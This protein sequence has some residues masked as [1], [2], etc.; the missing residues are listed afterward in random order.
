[1]FES[2]DSDTE[3]HQV[4]ISYTRADHDFASYLFDWLRGAGFEPWM[5]TKFL[6]PGQNWDFEINHALQNSSFIIV[7]LSKRSVDKRGYI[8]RE[9]KIALDLY[10]DKLIDDI[11]IIPVIIDDDILI[12]EQIKHLQYVS[13]KQPGYETKIAEAINIQ[14]ERL[15]GQRK[16]TQEEKDVYWSF[17]TKKEVWDG[18][19]GYEFEAQYISLSSDRFVNICEISDFIRGIILDH[20]FD[21][22]KNKIEQDAD[23]HSFADDQWSRTNTF[24]ASCSEPI[25]QNKFI[26][27]R[28][29]NS[30]YGAGAA[31]P[32]NYFETFCFI[33]DPLIRIRKLMDIFKNQDEALKLIRQ[34]VFD[35]L[36]SEKLEDGSNMLEEDWI[37]QGTE[38]W[39]SFSSFIFLAENI[40]ILFPP[41]SVGPYAA[42]S[43]EVQIPYKD[44][45]PLI[46]NQYQIALGIKYQ[47]S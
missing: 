34:I 23:N 47:F 28:Y 44:V 10:K 43:F 4:F 7:L 14:I 42:G 30:W 45:A 13:I 8:Q 20:L 16:K 12:P 32:N 24:Y 6:K 15:G 21:L 19:P 1:M 36:Q 37:K 2:I 3:P 39:E 38:D 46:A 18:L 29:L 17:I 25:F 31:H 26:S 35:S 27:I 11:F 9:L 22:R 41:Y 33:M 5:D 40:L